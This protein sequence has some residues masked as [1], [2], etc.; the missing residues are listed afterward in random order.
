MKNYVFGTGASEDLYDIWDYIAKDSADAA[1][2]WLG[3]L[4]DAFDAIAARPGIG[5][6]REDLIPYDV[7]LWPVGAYLIVYRT[8]SGPIEIVTITQGSRNLSAL[9][10]RRLSR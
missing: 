5:H 3:K 2:R 7:L 1:D 10:L 9:L 8:T 6:K 4:F